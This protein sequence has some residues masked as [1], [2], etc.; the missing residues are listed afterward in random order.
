MPGID[1]FSGNGVPGEEGP[2]VT[3][4]SITRRHTTGMGRESWHVHFR[5]GPP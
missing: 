5:L 4:G 2:R 1:P 3:I